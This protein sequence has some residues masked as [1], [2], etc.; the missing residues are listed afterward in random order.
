MSLRDLRAFHP[1]LHKLDRFAS[2]NFVEAEQ[3]CNGIAQNRRGTACL[4]DDSDE[5]CDLGKSGLQ[6]IVAVI[7]S[8]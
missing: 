2:A 5:D 1:A 7:L 4:R 8:A 6:L 3:F